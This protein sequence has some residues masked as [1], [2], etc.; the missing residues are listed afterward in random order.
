MPVLVTLYLFVLLSWYLCIC[1]L[2]YFVCYRFP[3]LEDLLRVRG[4]FDRTLLYGYELPSFF[5][6]QT[7]I[8]DLYERDTLGMRMMMMM[9]CTELKSYI[10]L[11]FYAWLT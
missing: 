6:P 3:S 10:S 5:P 7:L 2:L 9:I 4:L 8:I 1:L 11:D